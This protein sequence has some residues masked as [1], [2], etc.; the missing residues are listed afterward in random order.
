MVYSFN[1]FVPNRV[2]KSILEELPPVLVHSN[3]RA[4]TPFFRT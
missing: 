1:P 3:L 2:R 4:R